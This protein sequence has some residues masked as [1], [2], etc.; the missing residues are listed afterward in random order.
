MRLTSCALFLVACS[1]ATWTDAF[2]GSDARSTS[3]TA[4]DAAPPSPDAGSAQ[5]CDSL[6]NSSP[7]VPITATFPGHGSSSET[8][9][10]VA[11]SGTCDMTVDTDTDGVIFA[12]D[13]V[14][15]A[16]LLAPGTPESG[17]AQVSGTDS[18]NDM[19]F[20]WSYGLACTINDDYKLDKQ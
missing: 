11:A 7:T 5:S 10:I 9:H 3:V 2:A 12:S 13:A 19:L 17:T 6:A 16:S 20:Q 8:I 14:P 4:A 15:C 1:S 18:P